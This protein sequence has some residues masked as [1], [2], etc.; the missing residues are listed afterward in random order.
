MQKLLFTLS[1][2]LIAKFTISQTVEFISKSDIKLKPIHKS[3]PSVF[4]HPKTDTTQLQFVAA[5]KAIGDDSTSQPGGIFLTI[6]TSA[7]NLG[8]NFFRLRNF[9]YDSLKRPCIFID[10]YYGPEA[11]LAA[12]TTN[13]EANTVFI[14]GPSHRGNDTFA[15]KVN[16]TARP[17]GAETY[18]KFVLQEGEE[19]KLSK[20]GFT[21]TRARLKYQKN[22][23]P[24]YLMAM[25]GGIG[26]GASPASGA[27]GVSFNTGEIRDLTDDYGQFLALIL[28]EALE[29]KVTNN[30]NN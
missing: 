11:T 1:Y 25:G 28:K 18:L 8:A 14:F 26:G 3:K 13:Y 29:M 5:Y 16:N 24:I 19:L 23:L 6:K 7:R 4:I 17:F 21:G 22:K 20:G 2:I 10:A 27:I 30:N 12:N 9:Y 15:L